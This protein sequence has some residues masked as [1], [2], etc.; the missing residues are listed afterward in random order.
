M[1]SAFRLY[2][3]TTPEL[4]AFLS[5]TV[6]G[7]NGARYQHLDTEKRLQS[8]ENPLHL[9]LIRKDKILGNITFCRRGKNWYIRYFAFDTAFQSKGTSKT[10]SSQS[11]LRDEIRQFFQDKLLS[12]EVENFYAYID[13][14]NSRSLPFAQTLGFDVLQTI[15]TQT[16][17]RLRPRKQPELEVLTEPHAIQNLL[18]TTFSDHSFYFP[19]DKI[20]SLY[21][22]YDPQKE[23]IAFA[24][25]ELI[26]WQIHQFPGKMGKW[27]PKLVPYIPLVNQFIRP[28][29]HTFLGLDCVW[30]AQ[31]NTHVLEALLE[32]ILHHEQQ[33]LMI[34]WMNEHDKNQY[35]LNWGMMHKMLPTSEVFLV[36]LSQVKRIQ[37]LRTYI[38]SKDLS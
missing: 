29:K 31:Q 16:F 6:L 5:K 15:Y 34:W 3:E 36:Y 24:H 22:V 27:L 2:E 17:S 7:T 37:N 4:I 12:G 20:K 33:K 26:H 1:H 14:T 32:G 11:F 38:V 18:N 23:P 13:P 30:C 10:T 25:A 28:K 9:S 19:T 8:L 21:V 35:S